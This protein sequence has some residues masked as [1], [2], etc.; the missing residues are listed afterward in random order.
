MAILDC[1]DASTA[2]IALA[3]LADRLPD[4]AALHLVVPLHLRQALDGVV[5]VAAPK[6]RR[7][8]TI[9]A[10]GGTL[11]LVG[12]A[13][14][15]ALGGFSGSAP[16]AESVDAYP[17]KPIKFVCPFAAGGGTDVLARQ[18]GRAP[19]AELRRLLALVRAGEAD[20]APLP[21]IGRAHV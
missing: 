17:S 1:R 4:G 12:L 11:A 18:V 14:G 3:W 2:A 8:V 16:A 19:V 13:A 5:E 6:R 21:E 10:V 20:V 7:G 15:G 9:A